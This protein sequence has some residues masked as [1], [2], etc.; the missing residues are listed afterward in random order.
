[1][2]I[3]VC[4]YIVVPITLC[5]W[6]LLRQGWWIVPS[7]TKL[8]DE[9]WLYFR[10]DLWSRWLLCL[11]WSNLATWGSFT[12]I[13]FLFQS[14]LRHVSICI[15]RSW[16]WGKHWAG[17]WKWCGFLMTLS[18]WCELYDWLGRWWVVRSW[19]AR[20]NYIWCLAIFNI[21]DCSLEIVSYDLLM[22]VSL[23]TW[24]VL[25]KA[26]WHDYLT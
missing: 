3:E 19:L 5:Y 12:K 10:F 14:W 24:K 7:L 11:L 25:H 2:R 21:L 16:C 13:H 26:S 1:M 17:H 15:W 8:S 6:N 4:S 23:H 18:A 9:M 20:V 22:T